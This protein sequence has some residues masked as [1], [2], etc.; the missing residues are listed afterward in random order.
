MQITACQ[1]SYLFDYAS[2]AQ[3]GEHLLVALRPKHLCESENGQRKEGL[4]DV[5]EVDASALVILLEIV[6]AYSLRS[7]LVR[8]E[9][10][11]RG[12]SAG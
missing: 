11:R 6:E 10:V 7:V 9:L 3:A 4:S 2:L 1:K 12:S 5:N 8:P